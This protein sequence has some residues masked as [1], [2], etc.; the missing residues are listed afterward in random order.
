MV[1]L[2]FGNCLFSFFDFMLWRS[3]FELFCC[4]WREWLYELFN[5]SIMGFYVLK[6][7]FCVQFDLYIVQDL[8]FKFVVLYLFGI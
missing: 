8:R 2:R 3:I 6:L 7:L 1:F 5:F 4:G